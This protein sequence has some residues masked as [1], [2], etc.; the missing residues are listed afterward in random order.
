MNGELYVQMHSTSALSTRGNGRVRITAQKQTK[1]LSTVAS[2]YLS[3]HIYE[4][5]YTINFNAGKTWKTVSMD[6]SKGPPLQTPSYYT[7]LISTR[8]CFWKLQRQK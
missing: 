6:V 5:N 8:S 2:V 4:L 1:T 3:L 7:G